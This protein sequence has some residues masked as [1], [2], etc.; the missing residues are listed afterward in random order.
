MQVTTAKRHRYSVIFI[1]LLSITTPGPLPP[2]RLMAQD[3]SCCS[4]VKD[5]LSAVGQITPG[6][7]RRDVERAFTDDGGLSSRTEGRY[8]FR[9]CS[10]I[11]VK[12]K[13][14]KAAG[15]SV[16]ES[17]DDVVTEVSSLYIENPEMD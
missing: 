12:V 15:T 5:A 2:F 3:T 16:E 13:F 17:P 4:V 9:K 7:S 10:Y 8:V 14:S 6:M 1:A 11:K